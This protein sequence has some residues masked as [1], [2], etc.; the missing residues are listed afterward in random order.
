MEPSNRIF[1][2]QAD[3]EA[4]GPFG[5]AKD[6]HDERPQAVSRGGKATGH[7]VQVGARG[8]RTRLGVCVPF[9]DEM[10][11]LLETPADLALLLLQIGLV[12][13]AE[14]VIVAVRRGSQ[15]AR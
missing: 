14:A 9:A 1:P 11:A 6:D 12:G 15:R 7:G 5:R 2:V 8:L 13:V 10:Q 4:V 3:P